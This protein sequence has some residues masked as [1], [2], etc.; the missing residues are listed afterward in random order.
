MGHNHHI[1]IKQE[2][3]EFTSK[4][5]MISIVLLA[6]G[7]ILSVIGVIQIKNHDTSSS[8]KHQTEVT[9]ANTAEHASATEEHGKSWTLRFW[10]NLLINSY[11]FL[12]FGIGGLFFVALNYIANAGWATMIKRIAEA[13]SSYIPIGFIILMITLIFGG[14]ELYHWIHYE[15]LG[16]KEGMEGY[17][18][19]LDGKSGF[20]NTKFLFFG[21]PF[22][23]F[24]WYIFRTLLRRLSIKEDEQGG[25]TFFNKSVKL[26]AG[27]MVLFLFS[28]SIFA[29]IV[30][31][32]IDAHWYSTIY[33]V[34]N[35]G[36]LFVTSI[37][38]ISFF[39]LYLKS[40]GYME[41]VSSEI[42]HDL[43]KF[44][45]AFC[46]FWAYIW[47]AQFLLIWYANIHE[48]IVYYNIRL[49]GYFRP[50]FFINLFINFFIPFLILMTKN[51]KRNPKTLLLAGTC[52]LVGHWLDL[53]IMVMPGTMGES[54]GI[55]L[56]EIGMPIAFAGLFIYI[57]K[58]SLSKANL[59]PEKHPYI[60]E[61]ATYDVGV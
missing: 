29:W 12:L 46:I 7:L 49:H 35:W 54:S 10:A 53:Y 57:V 36:I 27:F 60:V 47:V 5:K 59:Y 45:F 18:K 42:L 2:K 58:N 33:S 3:F 38:I 26:S 32:S 16:L 19:I 1:D 11:Y 23:F 43:G 21:V 25:L 48:E 50:L 22:I 30:M 8:H 52:I 37:T 39:I 6:V 13:M 44:M 9:T 41:L 28:F 40:K 31:M 61:S 14:K 24:I 17:D 55:G 34:Y 51:A 15:H 56:L 4:S 20:L